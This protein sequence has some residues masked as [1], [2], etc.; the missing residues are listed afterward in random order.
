MNRKVFYRMQEKQRK[1]KPLTYWQVLFSKPAAMKADKLFSSGSVIRHHFLHSLR[2]GIFRVPV[3]K[4]T[5]F[6]IVEQQV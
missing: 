3:K 6:R 2:Q 1:L 4:R 5:R